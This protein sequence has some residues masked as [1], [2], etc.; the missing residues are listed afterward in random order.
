MEK[1][2]MMK[3]HG[4]QQVNKQIEPFFSKKKKK[5]RRTKQSID[6]IPNILHQKK[7]KIYLA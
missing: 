6:K 5:R 1:L 4:G 7:K 3:C 2:Q